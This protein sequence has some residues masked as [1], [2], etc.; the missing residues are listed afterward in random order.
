MT[1]AAKR[2]NRNKVTTRELDQGDFRRLFPESTQIG[3]EFY[4]D[5]LHIYFDNGQQVGR[6]TIHLGDLQGKGELL[7]DAKAATVRASCIGRPV[8]GTDRWDAP[9]APMR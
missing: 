3:R 7:P 2:K 5:I 6:W 4:R 8:A 1:R 9:P